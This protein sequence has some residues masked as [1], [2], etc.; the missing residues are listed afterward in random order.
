LLQG[1]VAAHA[2]PIFLQ[3]MNFFKVHRN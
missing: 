3:N 1:A 2:D